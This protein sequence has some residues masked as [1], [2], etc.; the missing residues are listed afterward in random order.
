MIVFIVAWLLGLASVFSIKFFGKVDAFSSNILLTIG[1]LVIVLFVGWK[2][3]K[4]DIRQEITN[5]GKVNS[6]AFGVL[7]FLIKYIAPIAVLTII[8]TTFVL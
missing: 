7:Y 6:K 3:K 8:I 4:E 5:G 1:A 2:M